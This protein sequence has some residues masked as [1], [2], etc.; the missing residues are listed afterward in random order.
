MCARERIELISGV[1]DE[2]FEWRRAAH[3]GN[4]IRHVDV[5]HGQY[6]EIGVLLDRVDNLVHS[7][8]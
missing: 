3:L 2:T 1:M 4:S 7:L 6:L 5:G 8:V